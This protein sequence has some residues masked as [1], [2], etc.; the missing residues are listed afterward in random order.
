LLNPEKG[1][2]IQQ[3]I[4]NCSATKSGNETDHHNA[5]QVEL[6]TSCLDDAGESKSDHPDDFEAN[7]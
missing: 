4:S 7:D 5:H 6:L 1:A 2:A 3:H